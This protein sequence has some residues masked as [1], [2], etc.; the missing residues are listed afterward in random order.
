MASRLFA[1]RE[2]SRGRPDVF[3]RTQ[4][5]ARQNLHCSAARASSVV[6]AIP[7]F[8]QFHLIVRAGA[9]RLLA[10]CVDRY[11]ACNDIAK[12]ISRGLADLKT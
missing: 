3:P 2:I 5:A 8:S 10:A 9:R 1:A 11:A 12:P 6:V 7:L 4:L